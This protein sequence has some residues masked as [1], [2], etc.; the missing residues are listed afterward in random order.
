MFGHY[1]PLGSFDFLELID[2]VIFAVIDAADPVSEKTLKPGIFHRC[3][4]QLVSV[5][6]GRDSTRVKIAKIGLVSQGL[7]AS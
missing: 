4:F 1:S 7:N 3:I 2:L 6:R 5:P